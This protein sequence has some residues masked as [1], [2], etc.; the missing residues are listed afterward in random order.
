MRIR[1]KYLNTGNEN[2]TFFASY[3]TR[4]FVELPSLEKGPF[5][6]GIFSVFLYVVHAITKYGTVELIVTHNLI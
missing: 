3:T 6:V 2:R 4:I 5:F 1:T